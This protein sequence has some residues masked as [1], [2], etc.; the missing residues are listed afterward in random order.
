MIMVSFGEGEIE[1]EKFYAAKR[2]KRTCD[3]DD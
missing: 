2:P 1:Q 3:V